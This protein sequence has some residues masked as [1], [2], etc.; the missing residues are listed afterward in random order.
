MIQKS[1]FALVLH[2]YYCYYF[3][4]FKLILNY[5]FIQKKGKFFQQNPPKNLL[6]TLN[7]IQKL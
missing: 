7:T 2:D 6:P 3:C 5:D 1:L 4:T